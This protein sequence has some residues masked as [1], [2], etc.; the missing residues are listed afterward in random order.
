MEIEMGTMSFVNKNGHMVLVSVFDKLFKFAN[1]AEI[2]WV[3]DEDGFGGSVSVNGLLPILKGWLI[4]DLK[5]VVD[6]RHDI[7]WDSAGNRQSTDNRFVDVTRKDD[8]LPCFDRGHD[9]GD[10]AARSSVD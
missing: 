7:N 8:L 9:H 5:I 3:D 4:G 6:L 2:G 10:D 1:R